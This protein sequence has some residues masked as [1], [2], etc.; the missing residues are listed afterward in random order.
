MSI[1][2]QAVNTFTFTKHVL[3]SIDEHMNL[4]DWKVEITWPFAKLAW[5]LCLHKSR[6]VLLKTPFHLRNSES[7]ET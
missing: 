1:I 5:T 4:D 6:P 7:L 3:W 2:S